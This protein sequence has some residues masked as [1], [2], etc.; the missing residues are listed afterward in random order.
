MDKSRSSD[1]DAELLLFDLSKDRG[2]KLIDSYTSRKGAI[3]TP[4]S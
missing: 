3:L 4:D 2:L 1:N